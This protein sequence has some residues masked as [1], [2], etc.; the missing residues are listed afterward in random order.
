MLKKRPAAQIEFLLQLVSKLVQQNGRVNLSEFC[1][2]RILESHLLQAA[3]PAR[4]PGNRVSKKAARQAAVNLIRLVADRGHDEPGERQRAFDAGAA[5]FG[6]WAG[7]H[8]TSP[9]AS[10]AVAILDDS[11]AA[12]RRM[13]SAGRQSLIRAVS[14]T[15]AYDGRL[16]LSEAELLRAICA[17]LDCPMPPI[18]ADNPVASP[19]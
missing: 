6:G 4:K 11:L 13:N 3:H 14:K 19:S 12:L 8:G 9:D 1:F 15:I 10:N 7:D 17:T 2:Y 5:L 18:L 16:T